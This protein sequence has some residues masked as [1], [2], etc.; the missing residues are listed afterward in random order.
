MNEKEN[1][2]VLTV[3]ENNLKP[4]SNR[5][6]QRPTLHL[7]DSP[8]LEESLAT[9]AANYP[10]FKLDRNS[11]VDTSIRWERYSFPT[12]SSRDQS[13]KTFCALTYG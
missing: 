11:V 4:S 1:L 7:V 10:T 3:S 12:D 8:T 6:L 2:Y 9:S 5:G 13:Y